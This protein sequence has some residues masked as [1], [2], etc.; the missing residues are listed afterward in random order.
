MWGKFLNIRIFNDPSSPI[1]FNMVLRKENFKYD[2]IPFNSNVPKHFKLIAGRSYYRT[3]CSHTSSKVELK[4]QLRVI[5]SILKRKGFPN[6][7]INQM[8]SIAGPKQKSLSVKK[9]QGTTVFDKVGLRHSFAT[10]DFTDSSLEKQLIFL[11][12][13][14]PGPKLE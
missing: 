6:W 9:F 4:N 12:M 1:P 8:S 3:V 11:P 5:Y 2:I 14:V 7:M 13:S 10:R